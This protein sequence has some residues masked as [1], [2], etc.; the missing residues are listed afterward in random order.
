[1]P[2][3]LIDGYQYWLPAELASREKEA[4]R[5]EMVKALTSRTGSRVARREGGIFLRLAGALG[6]F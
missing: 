2:T 5:R 1:M 3:E 6:L 4:R